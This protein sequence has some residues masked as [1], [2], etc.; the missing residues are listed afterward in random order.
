MFVSVAIPSAQAATTP[1][2]SPKSTTAD[3][4]SKKQQNSGLQSPES[5]PAMW[6][7]YAALVHTL[8][9]P[10]T[11]FDVTLSPL[12]RA[13]YHL[14]RAR[15]FAVLPWKDPRVGEDLGRCLKLDPSCIDAWNLMGQWYFENKDDDFEGFG[16]SNVSL[17][18]K[19]FESGLLV[20]RNVEGLLNLAQVLRME[21]LVVKQMSFL[22]IKENL[23]ESEKLCR[24][25]LMLDEMDEKMAK[26]SDLF[27]NRGTIHQF[28]E[29]YNQALIDFKKSA[30]FDPFKS[31]ED[32]W[33]KIAAI[34]K[35]LVDTNNAVNAG[36]DVSLAQRVEESAPAPTFLMQ[37]KE[38]DGVEAALVPEAV[39]FVKRGSANAGTFLR[40]EIIQ[41]VSDGLPRVFVAKDSRGVS[42]AASIFNTTVGIKVGDELLVGSPCAFR[43][44]L[45]FEENNIDF[46]NLRID[47]PALVAINGKCVSKEEIAMVQARFENL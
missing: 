14:V 3:I 24:E 34:H 6:G 35:L 36:R 16:T 15:M 43:I 29:N 10:H 19:C 20:K 8:N 23:E 40:F 22:K 1:P 45:S 28:N 18:K 7:E 41:R 32:N 37:S 2:E 11:A 21:E 5:R 4:I 12:L 17:A 44:S 9:S 46:V 26:C 33:E 39:G 25:A 30:C 27:G 47:Q 13:K 42:F 31:G 38:L